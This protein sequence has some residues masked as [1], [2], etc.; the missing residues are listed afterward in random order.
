MGLR[1]A[2]QTPTEPLKCPLQPRQYSCMQLFMKVKCA[3]YEKGCPWQGDLSE[4]ATHEAVCVPT[5]S[6]PPRIPACQSCGESKA[7]V[8]EATRQLKQLQEQDKERESRAMELKRMQEIHFLVGV[9]VCAACAMLYRMHA[10]QFW[11]K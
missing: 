11:R 9:G 7:Q 4:A 10:R 6:T 5:T 8:V 1:H 2:S 3:K